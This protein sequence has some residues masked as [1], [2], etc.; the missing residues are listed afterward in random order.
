[1]D[2]K[3]ESTVEAAR[4]RRISDDLL[5]K[6]HLATERFHQAKRLLEGASG[7]MQ[8][9]HQQHIDQANDDMRSAE[10]EVEEITREIHSALK[11]PPTVGND[12]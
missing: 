5:Q 1:M 4:E 11:P 9:S 8:Y 12:N 6:L 10:R 2:S 3:T 7:E